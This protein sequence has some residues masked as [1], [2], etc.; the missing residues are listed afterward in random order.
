LTSIVWS[1]DRGESGLVWNCTRNGRQAE[2]GGGWEK[3]VASQEYVMKI[4]E[5][6]VIRDGERKSGERREC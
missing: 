1:Q 6:C 2:I 4:F 3:L 5:R